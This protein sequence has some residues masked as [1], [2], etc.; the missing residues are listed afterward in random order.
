VLPPGVAA[1]VI[2]GARCNG[3]W[4][5]VAGASSDTAGRVQSIVVKRI[6]MN[7]ACEKAVAALM[8]LSLVSA[9][10]IDSPLLT[11]NL[12]LVHSRNQPPCFDEGPLAEPEISPRQ[13]GGEV[14]APIV[15]H[16]TEPGFPASARSSIGHGRNVVVIVSSIISREGCVRSIQLISQ[17]PYPELN[18]AALQAISQWTFEPGRLRG[19]RVDVIFYLTVNFKVP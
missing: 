10:S 8:R 1:A 18:G 4:L 15:K 2:A 13:T 7:D 16:R 12:L 3:Q 5:G 11:T 9:R 14:T 17:S 6:E 19:Q